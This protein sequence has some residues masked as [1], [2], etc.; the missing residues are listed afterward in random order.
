[1]SDRIRAELITR[2]LYR[3]SA[4]LSAE[5]RKRRRLEA[6]CAALRME[7]DFVWH[8]LHEA[9]ANEQNA[10]EALHSSQCGC[11]E[12]LLPEGRAA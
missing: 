12:G 5:I 6:E 11:F 2:D 7:V 10:T 4:E 9:T 3:A 1:M 8:L